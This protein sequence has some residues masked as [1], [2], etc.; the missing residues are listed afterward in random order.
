[1]GITVNYVESINKHSRAIK[2]SKVFIDELTERFNKYSLYNKFSIQ[3]EYIFNL[4]KLMYS[5]VPYCQKEVEYFESNYCVKFLTN[6]EELLS[7]QI[8][9]DSHR[10]IGKI[11]NRL[12]KN[13]NEI[14]SALKDKKES[15]LN[16]QL[17][18]PEPERI[19]EIKIQSNQLNRN[20]L[21]F[22][23]NPPN[24]KF[25]KAV[26]M[27]S[28]DCDRYSI[29]KAFEKNLPW[30]VTQFPD[31]VLRDKI[32]DCIKYHRS[33]ENFIDTEYESIIRF[34]NL[35]V[36]CYL[37]L[38]YDLVTIPQALANTQERFIETSESL[39]EATDK[40]KYALETLINK[41]MTGLCLDTKAQ[42]NT[43]KNIVDNI[44]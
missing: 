4:H 44:L 29:P 10:E 28:L 27:E 8:N 38:I 13:Y 26:Y 32:R 17:A 12:T 31:R 7:N 2:G 1:M 41:F 20:S 16:Q 11:L 40:L 23:V 3:L 6:F 14:I 36:S 22:D 30:A 43:F 19:R 9:S 15:I 24:N 18:K 39:N 35:A 33:L 37:E 25:S 5:Y 42:M 34:E 21:K